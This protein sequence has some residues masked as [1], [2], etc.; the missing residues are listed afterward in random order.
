MNLKKKKLFGFVYRTGKLL[1]TYRWV[2]A[3][4]S[5]VPIQ[6]IGTSDSIALAHRYIF[7]L[8]YGALKLR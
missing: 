8:K 7:R 3:I 5:K 6:S 4:L 2:K 1:T